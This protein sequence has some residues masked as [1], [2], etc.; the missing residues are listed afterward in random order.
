ME[1]LMGL[2][3]WHLLLFLGIVFFF[4]GTTRLPQI[5]K[6]LREFNKNLKKGVKGESD[7]D[8]TDKSKK[9]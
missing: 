7:I 8:I 3:F 6:G 4:F 5:G 1:A 9:L 2:S